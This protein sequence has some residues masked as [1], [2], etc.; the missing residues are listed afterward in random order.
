MACCI[1]PLHGLAALALE[2]A[3][4]LMYGGASPYGY[5]LTKN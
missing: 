1:C 5:M 4:V 2:L 3:C